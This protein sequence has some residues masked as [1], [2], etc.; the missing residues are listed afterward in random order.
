[1]DT[2][3]L[4]DPGSGSALIRLVQP[5]CTGSYQSSRYRVQ[6]ESSSHRIWSA[7][8]TVWFGDFLSGRLTQ[9]ILS[10]SLATPHGAH[11]FELT[12]ENDY[13]YM[14]EGDFIER[15]HVLRWTWSMDPDL[16]LSV[17]TQ[18]EAES[19]TLGL[20]ARLRWTLR[21]GDDLFLVWTRN[22]LDTDP[23]GGLRFMRQ[24]DAVVAK[25]RWTF[26]R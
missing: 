10:S 8:A 22:W 6:A 11:R 24:S 3:R 13:G 23:D 15:L 16:G 5:P 9:T 25:V 17:L 7:A 20:N 19:R 1:M 26:R 12:T 4:S 21:P 2:P 14:P 18:Y